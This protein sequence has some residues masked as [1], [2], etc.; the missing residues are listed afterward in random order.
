[1]HSLPK[2]AIIED[3]ELIRNMYKLKLELAGYNVFTA[4]NG[5]LGFELIKS[6]RPDLVLLDIKMPV[7]PGNAMLKR[8]REDLWDLPLKVIVLTNIS[9][10][11]APPEFKFLGVSRYIVKAHSTPAQVLT[12][13]EE[14]LSI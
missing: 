7:L 3:D 10:D 8:V 12:E 13:I 14:V 6:I 5:L 9:K 4:E 2:I 1:M 11:E